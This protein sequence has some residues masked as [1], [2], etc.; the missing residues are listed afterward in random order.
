LDDIAREVGLSPSQRAE[1]VRLLW[2]QYVGQN[3]GLVRDMLTD[4][5]HLMASN[6]SDLPTEVKRAL[7]HYNAEKNDADV[8]LGLETFTSV[9]VSL[10]VTEKVSYD[11]IVTVTVPE[12]IAVDENALADYLADNEALW[13]DYL[14]IDGR[15]G[16]VD[17][18]ERALQSIR[19]HSSVEDGGA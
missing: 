19:I 4:V 15:E 18:N 11:F 8:E 6:D 14:S 10:A 1:R 16:S 5:L 17:V 12:D 9:T 7:A 3:G 13:L 2:Q